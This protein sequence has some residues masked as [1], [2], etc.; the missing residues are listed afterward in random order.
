MAKIN[1]REFYPFYHQ[2]CFIEVNDELAETL[3]AFER[4]NESY[5]RKQRRNQAFYSLNRGDGIE[6]EILFASP[7]VEDI[8][9]ERTMRNALYAAIDSLSDKQAKRVCAHY[10][11][12]MSISEIARVEGVS[13][14]SVNRS[15]QNGLSHL[16]E[17]L[18]RLR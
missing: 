11:L 1:L 4:A 18:K 16:A 17:K 2:D 8:F 3:R 6:H 14:H 9:E 12:G 13:W 15:I 5:K 7:S 10:L